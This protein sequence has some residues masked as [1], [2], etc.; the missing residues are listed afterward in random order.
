MSN[1]ITAARITAAF[2]DANAP[3]RRTSRSK[4]HHT[5]PAYYTATSTRAQRRQCSEGLP[6]ADCNYFHDCLAG[7]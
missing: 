2:L 6:P 3:A 4:P 1:A 5:E 7:S